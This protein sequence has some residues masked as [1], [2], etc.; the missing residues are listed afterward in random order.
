MTSQACLPHLLKSKNPH[1]VMLSP[2]LNMDAR[3]FALGGTAYTM[4]KYGMSMCVLGF[5]E[6]FRGKVSVNALWPQTAIATAA[7][8]MLGG[9][10]AVRASR[11]PEIVADAVHWIVSQPLSAGV[12][13]NFFIDEDILRQKLGKTDREIAAYAVSP[14]VPLLPDFF[15]GDPAAAEKLVGMG[16]AMQKA[17]KAVGAFFSKFK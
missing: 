12:S 2:P 9:S 8:E 11:K 3:W 16:Q 10:I 1:I 17:S 15:I 6:E 5:S 14:G 7:I 4:A 13:G